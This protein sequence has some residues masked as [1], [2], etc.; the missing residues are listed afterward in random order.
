MRKVWNKL[1]SEGIY[2]SFESMTFYKAF[3]AGLGNDDIRELPSSINDYLHR[4]ISLKSQNYNHK[5]SG[6]CIGRYR[7]EVEADEKSFDSEG[8]FIE[9]V[10]VSVDSIE[11]NPFLYNSKP[12][13]RLSKALVFASKSH[14]QQRRKSDNSPYVE[15]LIEVMDLLA[16][17]GEIVDEDIIIAGVL[18]DIIEDTKVTESELKINFGSRVSSMVMALTDDKTQPLSNRRNRALEKLSSTP[19]SVKT[20]KLADACA[21]ASGI[22]ATWAE[23]RL[24]EYFIWL[25][26][27][28]IECRSANEAL[29]Q[30]YSTR[31]LGQNSL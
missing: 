30:E 10:P 22:P 13:N 17:T 28:A 20:I 26:Q 18:H 23:D 16:N 5:I 2:Y 7:D 8:Y 15:H 4:T 11:N 9:L 14:S 12:Y 27:V 29:F 3:Y 31:R 21:N 19:G 6:A 1:L 25:D 24:A